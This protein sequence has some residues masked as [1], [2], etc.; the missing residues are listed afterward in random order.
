LKEEENTETQL[1]LPPPQLPL[2][3]LPPPQLPLPL[4]PPP[5]PP[6]L[7]L[8]Q[9]QVPLPPLPP[10]PQPPLEPPLPKV[11]RKDSDAREDVPH[12]ENAEDGKLLMER[13]PRKDKELP[14]KLVTPEPIKPPVNKDKDATGSQPPENPPLDAEANAVSAANGQTKEV[15]A[16][17]E[18]TGPTNISPRETSPSLHASQEEPKKSSPPQKPK[19]VPLKLLLKL[20]QKPPPQPKLPPKLPP[21]QEKPAIEYSI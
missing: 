4:L 15:L 14:A 13:E 21:Q 1:L 16:D 19:D 17:Q 5:Q 3:L 12:Q 2:P 10:P 20:P 18:P 7:L 6:P 8:P 9:L 11:P